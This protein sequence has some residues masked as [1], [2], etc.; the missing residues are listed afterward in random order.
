LLVA[1]ANI[2]IDLDSGGLMGEA[3]NALDAAMAVLKAHPQFSH[4]VETIEDTRVLSPESHDAAV[5]LIG[6][7][8]PAT[9]AL[10]KLMRDAP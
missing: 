6:H 9:P 2:W 3:V 8:R 5:D 7:S 1:D 4:A 10:R